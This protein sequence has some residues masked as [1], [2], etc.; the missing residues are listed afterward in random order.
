MTEGTIGNCW[1]RWSQR[2]L[3]VLWFRE[4][5]AHL[6]KLKF[7]YRG[8]CQLSGSGP[9]SWVVGVEGRRFFSKK[10]SIVIL[11]F[12]NRLDLTQASTILGNLLNTLKLNVKQML[13]QS[14]IGLVF[15][16]SYQ[17]NN[18]RRK[19]SL[20]NSIDWGDKSLI[21][22]EVTTE[23]D[24]NY[25]LKFNAMCFLRKSQNCWEKPLTHLEN[26]MS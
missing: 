4:S 1:A 25:S 7:I 6:S 14:Y 20:C 5:M 23:S 10:G 26:S 22:Y 19:F 17:E 12:H 24:M 8:S 18:P 9:C 13:L 21:S 11:S 15:S 3:L 2:S 16:L